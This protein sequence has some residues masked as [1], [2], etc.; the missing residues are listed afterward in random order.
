MARLNRHNFLVGRNLDL[1]HILKGDGDASLDAG[2]ARKGRMPTAFCCKWTLGQ[3]GKKNNGRDGDSIGGL[4]DALRVYVSL[5]LRP[6]G[7][8]EVIIPKLVACENA[9]VAICKAQRGTLLTDQ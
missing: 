7:A 3:S 1:L 5:K 6:V 9:M 8:C 4:E 2:R